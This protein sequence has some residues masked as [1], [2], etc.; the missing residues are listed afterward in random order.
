MSKKKKRDKLIQNL[1][2]RI[3]MLQTELTVYRRDEQYRRQRERE[4][5]RD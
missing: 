1:L 5:S 2:D 4:R 3:L